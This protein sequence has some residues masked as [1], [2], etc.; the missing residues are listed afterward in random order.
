MNALEQTNAYKGGIVCLLQVV[1][2]LKEPVGILSQ[3]YCI[4][5]F[6]FWQA[7]ILIPSGPLPPFF[8]RI[9]S[10]P[11]LWNMVSTLPIIAPSNDTL[12]S[13]L[14]CCLKYYI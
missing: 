13:F 6:S 9:G 3:C 8:F 14:F 11:L 5:S 10:F 12:A 4:I 7:I 2:P 1:E